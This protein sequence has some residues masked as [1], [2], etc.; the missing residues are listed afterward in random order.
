MEEDPSRAD[1][2]VVSLALISNLAVSCCKFLVAYLTGSSALLA[3]G[4]HSLADSSNQVA[5]LFGAKLSRRPPDREHPFGHGKDRYVWA[6]V[7]SIL[8]FIVGALFSVLEGLEK[9]QTPNGLF[10]TELA[11]LVIGISA[12][13]ES[14]S[15][16]A[17]FSALRPFIKTRGILRALRESKSPGIFVTFLED[18]AALLGL[19]LAFTGVLLTDLTGNPAFDGL[20]SIGIGGLLGVI[21]LF[22][23][24]ETRSLIIGEGLSQEE[25]TELKRAI[26]KVP[27][28]KEVLELLT[29]YLGPDEILVNVSVNFIDGLDTDR[30]EEAIDKV[31]RAIEE[32]LPSVKKVFVEAE[33]LPKEVLP[34]KLEGH[35]F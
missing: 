28:V 6:F 3:E 30:L 15:L 10:R 14:F 11:Y 26:L 23:S 25:L 24:Y 34:S 35:K 2:K 20:A 17:A 12:L 21:A 13:F 7:A 31:K 29:M 5:L 9:L 32:T 18:S 16:R 4:F 8:I 19:C 27:E 33:S 22:I 1:S